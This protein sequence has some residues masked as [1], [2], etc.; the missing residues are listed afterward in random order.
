MFFNNSYYKYLF[1]NCV[2]FGITIYINYNFL[3]V[4][5]YLFIMDCFTNIR[6]YHTY[7]HD[8]NCFYLCSIDLIYDLKY[9]GIPSNTAPELMV[10]KLKSFQNV[11]EI[12]FLWIKWV[13][14]NLR[15]G[16]I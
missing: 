11:S 13:Y 2:I 6:C 15:F 3:S 12:R 16:Y 10:Q 7:I 5:D 1:I 14:F 4:L 8:D 9:K